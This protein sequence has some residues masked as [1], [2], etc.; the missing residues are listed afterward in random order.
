MR[1][2]LAL[3]QAVQRLAQFRVVPLGQEVQIGAAGVQHLLHLA[4][5]EGFGQILIVVQI[6][7]RHLRL[8][9][10]ELGEVA[11]RVRILRAEGGAEGVDVGEGVREDLRLQLP[12]H[13]QVRVLAEEILREIGRLAALP[14]PLQVERGHLE[15]A[16]RAFGVRRPRSPACAHTGS[17][18]P[19]RICESPR[20]AHCAP[21][22]PRRTYWTASAGGRARA[23][24]P[25]CASSSAADSAP[26]RAV[27]W[28]VSARAFNS[29]AW[30][31]PIDAD[32]FAL[33]ADAGAGGDLGDRLLAA[34]RRRRARPAGRPARSRR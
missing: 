1:S 33:H 34:P 6:A 31:L 19:G 2:K 24:S 25:A 4:L 8:D 5:E 3:Q 30:P 12:A 32:Q 29:T 18:D 14:E 27:P 28:M 26:G 11:R 17:R 10:V 9:H 13:R 15:H 7:E 20:P 23:A 21:G 22:R 16:A